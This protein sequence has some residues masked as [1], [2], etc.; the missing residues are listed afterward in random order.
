VKLYA[1]YCSAHKDST[2][3]DLPAADR[4]ISD[5]IA[6]VYTNA[7][8][9]ECRFGILSGRFGLITPTQP[10]PD[11]DH[12]LQPSEIP[13]MA[14]RVAATLKQ[15]EV[16]SIQWFTVAFEMDPHVSRYSDVMTRAA[17]LAGID[18]ELELWE[19]TG[20]LGLV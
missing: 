3:G 16:T 14:E 1:T 10:I 7:M 13:S 6:G 18:F 2:A 19:P 5:R 15:W 17:E 8:S 20:M 4:Y 9:S 11:Y 12:L